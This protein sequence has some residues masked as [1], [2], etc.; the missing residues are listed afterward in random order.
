MFEFSEY[1]SD[2]T[3]SEEVGDK[4]SGRGE[5]KKKRLKNQKGTL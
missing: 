2:G 1:T 4:K 3:D 5:R